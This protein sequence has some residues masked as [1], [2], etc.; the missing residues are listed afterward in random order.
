MTDIEGTDHSSPVPMIRVIS[1]EKENSRQVFK[2]NGSVT[3]SPCVECKE[4]T[5]FGCRLNET[6]EDYRRF[7][8]ERRKA[9]G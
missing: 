7:I 9:T 1:R 2:G 3:L 8:D 6:C 5:Y 4:Y